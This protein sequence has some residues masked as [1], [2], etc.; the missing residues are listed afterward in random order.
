[1]SEKEKQE[2]IYV[3]NGVEKFDGNLIEIS[4]CLSDLANEHRFEYNGKSYVKLKVT[5]KKAVDNYGKT[6]SV[7]INQYKPPVKEDY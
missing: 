6:H 4:V 3:G 2:P 7:T 5:K 1:M